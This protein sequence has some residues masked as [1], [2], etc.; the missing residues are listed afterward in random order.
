MKKS[1]FLLVTILFTLNLLATNDWK[2]WETFGDK[3][4]SSTLKKN[5]VLINQEGSFYHDTNNGRIY[6][7]FDGDWR[8]IYDWQTY[9]GCFD[10][11]EAESKMVYGAGAP[12]L[13]GGGAVHNILKGF[14]GM[15]WWW[16][17]YNTWVT[18]G[19]VYF[20]EIP[21]SSGTVSNMRYITSP[22]E[23]DRYSF[24]WQKIVRVTQ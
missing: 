20:Y 24:D 4:H 6:I 10:I 13:P 23:F 18:D 16:T 2:S 11:D 3:L 14:L 12:P 19:K 15:R 8:W 5:A 21:I 1:T 22:A 9:S 17:A 7:Y